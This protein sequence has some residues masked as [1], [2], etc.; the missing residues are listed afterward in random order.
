MNSPGSEVY[1]MEEP[2]FEPKGLRID[3]LLLYY[4]C[5]IWL[6]DF[7][8]TLLILEWTWSSLKKLTPHT[9]EVIVTEEPPRIHLW[10]CKDTALLNLS[11]VRFSKLKFTYCFSSPPLLLFLSC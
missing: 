10:T 3:T 7:N 4:A 8:F 11:F 2:G 9:E 6:W 1:L 5:V